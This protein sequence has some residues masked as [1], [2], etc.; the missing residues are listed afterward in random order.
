MLEDGAGFSQAIDV[1]G[2][3][4][5]AAVET[6]VGVTEVINQQEDDVWLGGGTG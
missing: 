1:R 5:F 3:D 4:L 6:A 2:K